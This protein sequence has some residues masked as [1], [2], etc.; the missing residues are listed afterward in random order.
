[1]GTKDPIYWNNTDMGLFGTIYEAWAKHFN[2]RTCP[3]DW[4]LPVISRVARLVDD[5]ANDNL[6]RKYFVNV[7]GKQ[8]IEVM[9]DNFS[10]YDTD[11][12][13]V[14][15]AFSGKINEK[16]NVSGYTD[17]I[18]ASFSTT[19]PVQ[20]IG[21]QITI[22]KSFQKYFDYRLMVCGCGIKGVEMSGTEEDWRLLL[23][24]LNKLTELLA[25]IESVLNLVPYFEHV[26]HVYDHLLK[27]YLGNDV[28]EW[29]S[30]VLVDDVGI[31]YGSSGMGREVPAYNGWL[32]F[33]CYGNEMT[34]NVQD[35]AKGEYSKELSCLS[36]CPMEIIDVVRKKKDTSTL[37]AGVLGYKQYNETEN[38]VTSLEPV[39]GWVLMLPEKSPLLISK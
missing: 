34:L 15:N 2:L 27:T 33:F 4:W 37:M 21:S 5:K 20:R 32:V 6:V 3:E 22:M 11:F 31:K 26:R 36:Y 18:T 16:I 25:P 12:T 19:N 10:I 9:V 1:V 24:K 8:T 28:D 35:L 7:P 38:G 30:Q 13:Q 17:T 29:W 14:F 39:H 23:T